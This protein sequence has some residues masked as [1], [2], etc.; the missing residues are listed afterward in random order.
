MRRGLSALSHQALQNA[1]T[2]KRATLETLRKETEMT[3]A[4]IRFTA[5]KIQE[6]QGLLGY[7]GQVYEDVKTNTDATRAQLSAIESCLQSS[8]DD[9][10]DANDND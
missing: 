1:Y 5:A 10:A 3:S 6:A 7:L 4:K 8:S 2:A 9:V